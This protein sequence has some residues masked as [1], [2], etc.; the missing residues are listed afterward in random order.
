MDVHLHK[1][2]FI[3]TELD[4]ILEGALIEFTV[5]D[6]V[7]LIQ[8]ITTFRNGTLEVKATIF[9]ANSE[10]P[11]KGKC[12]TQVTLGSDFEIEQA[13]MCAQAGK[14]FQL[15]LELSFDI[16]KFDPDESDEDGKSI[17]ARLMQCLKTDDAADATRIM[18]GFFGHGLANNY[19]SAI[20]TSIGNAFGDA[21][22]SQRLNPMQM[23]HYGARKNP[24]FAKFFASVSTI[25]SRRRR[26]YIPHIGV[27]LRNVERRAGLLETHSF[28]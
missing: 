1:S 25:S 16:T 15:P 22:A 17:V 9:C 14:D 26:I 13:M 27:D 23:L 5:S 12:P 28:G 19:S 21:L 3:G 20:S 8:S 10:K 7:E 11:L 18:K 24:A 4:G 6:F 2:K